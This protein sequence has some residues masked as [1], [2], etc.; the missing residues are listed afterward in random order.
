MRLIITS[1]AAALALSLSA[2][3]FAA[4]TRDELHSDMAGT[5]HIAPGGKLTLVLT[6]KSGASRFHVTIHFNATVRSRTMLGFAVH[7]CRSTGCAGAST[8][9]I[10]LGPGTRRV[11]FHGAV[12]VVRRAA[13]GPRSRTACVYTQLRDLGPRGRAPGRV[14]R[15]S[16]RKGLK[17]LTVCRSVGPPPAG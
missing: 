15:T 16:G 13:T 7:P 10:K 6:H 11:T 4:N 3:A 9:T 8:S 2:V 14:L 12:R 17:G 5:S 1:L